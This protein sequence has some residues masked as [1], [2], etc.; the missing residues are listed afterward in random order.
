[1]MAKDFLSQPVNVIQQFLRNGQ[2]SSLELCRLSLERI[3]A[4]RTLNAFITVP[5]IRARDEATNS[6]E[7]LRQGLLK[8]D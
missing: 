1:M 5:D 6:D 2:L 7:R 3:G 8:N 4:T